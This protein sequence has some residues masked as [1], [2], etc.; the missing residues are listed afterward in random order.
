MNDREARRY[1]MFGRVQTFCVDNAADFAPG[2]AVPTRAAT[3][4]QILRDLDAAK[5][6]QAGGGSTT[7]EVLLDALRLDV[8]NVVRTARALDQDDPGFADLFRAPDSPSQ[9]ALLT[10]TD[11]ILAKLL[12]QSSDDTPTVTT[13]Q[14]RAAKFIAHE[15]SATFVQDLADDRAAIAAA[16][17][18]EESQQAE[19]VEST[20][21]IGWLI[22]AGM[23]EVTYLDAILHNKYARQPEKLRAWESASHVERAPQRERTATAPAATSTSTATPASVAA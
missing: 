9:L 19:G 21:A 17:D 1:D 2:S 20:A 16:Q 14:A 23:K 7:K 12:P 4:A 5:A 22:R 18:A 13:K 11:A 8:Q 6:A 3:L 15:L 10:A